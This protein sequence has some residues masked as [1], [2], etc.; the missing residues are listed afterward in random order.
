MQRRQRQLEARHDAPRHHR[1]A[2][3]FFQ[4]GFLRLQRLHPNNRNVAVDSDDSDSDN[5]AN[6]EVEMVGIELAN[7]NGNNPQFNH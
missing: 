6:G 1:L 2:R 5:E 3:A 4:D 7:G